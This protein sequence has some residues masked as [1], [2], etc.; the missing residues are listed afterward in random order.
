V[1]SSPVGTRA[2]ACQENCMQATVISKP[3][4]EHSENEQ[5]D[6]DR[7]SPASRRR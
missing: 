5:H 4:G 1:G 6:A 2:C 7:P 3:T